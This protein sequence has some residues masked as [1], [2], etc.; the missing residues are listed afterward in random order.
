MAEIDLGVPHWGDD[1][2]HI[3]GVLANYLALT[4]PAQAPDAQFRRVAVQA[5]ALVAELAARAGRRN[6]LRGL[7]VRFCLGRFRRLGGLRET[8]KFYLVKLLYALRR[9]LAPVGQELVGR[10][11]LEQPDDI[12]LL[13]LPE[14]RAAVAGADVRPIVHR[15]REELTREAQR[16]RVPRILLSDGSEPEATAPRARSANDGRPAHTRRRRRLV[17]PGRPRSPASFSIR[18]ALASSPV[19]SWS[20][21]PPTPA[22]RRSS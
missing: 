20:P 12:Y 21:H 17:W 8:P 1:P 5:D 10:G 3:L 15:R 22:G 14:A 7:A 18:T 13:T 4:E 6:A 16:R 2:T 19:R 9:L 11:L